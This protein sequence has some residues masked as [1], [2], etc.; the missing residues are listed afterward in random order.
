[1]HFL[2]YPLRVTA[3]LFL[4]SNIALAKLHTHDES[5]FPDYILRATAQNIT[6]DCATR[7]SVVFNGTTPGPPVYLEEGQ[8]TWIRV[9]NDM[10]DLNLTTHW[11]GLS[12]RAAPFSDGTPQVSQFPIGP[13]HY[14]DYEVHPE[15]GD[16]GTYFYHSH[17][18]FQLIT[19]SGPLIVKDCGNLPYAYDDDIILSLG[20]YYNN[21]D[22]NIETGLLADPFVWSGET[23]ALLVNGQS[24]TSGFDNATDASCAPCTIHVD[25]EKTYR[26]RFIGMTAISLIT[27]GIES[28]SNLSI[29]EADGADTKPFDVDHMQIHPG[30]RFSI[31]LQTKTLA[32]LQADNKSSYWIKYENRDRPANISGYAL[33]SYNS[34]DTPTSKPAAL[35]STAPLTLPQSINGWLEYALTPLTLSAS[36]SFPA[37][38]AVTRTVTITVKQVPGNPTNVSAG[39]LEWGQDGDIWQTSRVHNPYLVSIYENGQTAIPNYTAAL[40]NYGWDPATLAFPALL[41]EVLDIV[42]LNDNGASGGWDIHPFH[43]HGGHYWDLGSGNGTYNAT[44]NEAQYFS[45]GFVPVKRDTTMLYRYASSGVPNTASGWRAWRIKVQDPGAWMMHCHILAHMIMGKLSKSLH[46][47][48]QECST[49]NGACRHADCVGIW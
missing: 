1:M 8:T 43:A 12:Q 7:Y 10:A 29:V 47:S 45:N 11:H 23:H 33:L 19:A 18:G 49:A 35:P 37:L 42:W 16:A 22:T 34:P 14:F 5:F 41:G 6:I 30:A 48:I 15:S 28:H 32:E 26:I 25:P 3:T 20:D 38:S 24:G 36:D 44:E 27:L 2:L 13:G 9:F 39:T 46:S 17:V 4:L 21:T 40:S 31:L